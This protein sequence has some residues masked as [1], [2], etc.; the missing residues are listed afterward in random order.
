MVGSG[1]QEAENLIIFVDEI[2]NNKN[3]IFDCLKVRYF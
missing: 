2:W 3:L 1:Q